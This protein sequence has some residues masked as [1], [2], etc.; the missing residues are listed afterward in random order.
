MEPHH[1]NTTMGEL[2]PETAAMIEVGGWVDDR[3]TGKKK[4]MVEKKN[5]V[6]NAVSETK[7]NKRT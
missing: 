7:V 4:W 5:K 6:Q 3:K 2:H 1:T